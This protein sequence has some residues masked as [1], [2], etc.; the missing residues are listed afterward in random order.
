MSK[1]FLKI[2][3]GG[4]RMDPYGPVWVRMVPGGLFQGFP[5][6]KPLKNMFFSDGGGGPPDPHL[7][8]RQACLWYLF[9]L[10][11]GQSLFS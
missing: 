5:G 9:D 3:L 4:V 8:G 7:Y 2:D 6:P 11:F 1:Y 10:V